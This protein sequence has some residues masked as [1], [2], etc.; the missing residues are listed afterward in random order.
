MKFCIGAHPH[1]AP[2]STRYRIAT[3]GGALALVLVVASAAA[4]TSVVVWSA[5]TMGFKVKDKSLVGKVKPGD[6]VDFTLVQSGSD[7]IITSIR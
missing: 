2:P 3:L 7:Y 1:H 4:G 6:K 5:M